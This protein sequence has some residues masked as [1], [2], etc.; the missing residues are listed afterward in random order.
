MA[1]D[2]P[3]ISEYFSLFH[4]N[5]A[6]NRTKQLRQVYKLYNPQQRKNILESANPQ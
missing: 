5:I 1:G 2:K 4:P 3:T 6:P